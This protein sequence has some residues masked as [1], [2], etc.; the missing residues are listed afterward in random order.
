MKNDVKKFTDIFIGNSTTHVDKILKTELFIIQIISNNPNDTQKNN[1]KAIEEKISIGNFTECENILKKEYNI[2]QNTVLLMKKAEFCSRLD[3]ERCFNP[4]A[5]RGLIF[6]F[7]DPNTMK[8]LNSDIC[9]TINSQI[10]IPF[11][12]SDRINMNTYEISAIMNPNLDLYNNQSLA[13]HSRCV[14]SINI[15]TFA[16]I[17]INYKRSQMFQNTSITCSSGCEYDGLDKNKFVKCNC[18]T[19]GKNETSNTGYEFVFDPLPSM[20]YDIVKCYRET[21]KD[22]I[23]KYFN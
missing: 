5:S 17:S 19:S 12:R 22:V 20:N 3:V 10:S 4:L 6:E 23:I 21:I 16:D 1:E 8:K 13:Y 18:N 14:K 15:N 9:N 11:K 7:I 2:S